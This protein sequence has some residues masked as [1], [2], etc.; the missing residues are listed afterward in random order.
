MTRLRLAALIVFVLAGEAPAAALADQ[1]YSVS[2]SDT[3]V[4]GINDIHNDV[5]YRGAE[6]LT[7]VRRGQ[8]TRYVAKLDC[9]RTEQ[10]ADSNEKADYVAD[11]LPSGEQLDAADHDPDFLTI[12]NQP[13]SVQLDRATLGDLRALHGSLP[14]DFPSPMTGSA[15]HGLLESAGSGLIGSRRALGVKF[16]AGGPM[17]GA[18]PER[19][20]LVLL[21]NI[22]MRGTAYYDVDT[23]LLLAL[24]ATVTIT[25]KL[26]DRGSPDPVRIVYK[27]TLRALEPASRDSPI[28]PKNS[29]NS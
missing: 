20:G 28:K 12:L 6:T 5:L 14:F 9:T 29:R 8:A 18:L 4:I 24:E 19:P 16:R 10:G 22:V 25:G 2:G 11:I 27:R 23:A 17:R 1:T 7:I 3:F 26:T 13:F 15:L 21:G